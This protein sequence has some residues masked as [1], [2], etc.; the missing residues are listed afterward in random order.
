MCSKTTTITFCRRKSMRNRKYFGFAALVLGLSVTAAAMPFTA[1]ADDTGYELFDGEVT[2]LVGYDNPLD[3]AK[4]KATGEKV[5]ASSYSDVKVYLSDD[6][7]TKLD[8]D[9]TDEDPCTPVSEKNTWKTGDKAINYPNEGKYVVEFKVGSGDGAKTFEG[10]DALKVNAIK[11]GALADSLSFD[12]TKADAATAAVAQEGNIAETTFTV[13]SEVKDTIKSKYY[14]ESDIFYTVYYSAPGADF[15]STS[16]EKGSVHTISLSA[17]GEYR[18]YVVAEDNNGNSVLPELADGEK[19]VVGVSGDGYGLFKED[20]DGTRDPALLAP[21]Y[22][23]N[24]TKNNELKITA[25]GGGV[26]GKKG[27]IGQSYTALSFSVENY[28]SATYKLLY[29]A[30]GEWTD[31][32]YKEAENGVD[33]DFDASSF[34]T[35]SMNFTP[36][37]VGQYKVRI[38]VIGGEDGE[39]IKTQDSNAVIVDEVS[40]ELPLV[41]LRVQQFFQ[42][43]WRSLIFLG[44]AVLCLAGIVVIALWKPKNGNNGDNGDGEKTEESETETAT[45]EVTEETAEETETENTEEETEETATEE[46]AT[47]ESPSEETATEGTATEEPKEEETATE[48]S[49]AEETTEESLSEETA[50]EEPKEE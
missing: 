25:T 2:E 5:A 23:F 47:E 39:E 42:S 11:A 37:K 24:Y 7:W 33:A 35:S 48:E 41:D 9:D 14:S 16:R 4:D 34:T 1:S 18:F 29:S 32:N 30:D 44:I 46:T 36:L 31:G 50:T 26:S 45:E 20:K 19:F 6:S 21:V 17:S 22:F 13:P 3:Y 12:F 49:P 38:T 40:E 10:A 43:N 28:S 27:I 8:A 15:T